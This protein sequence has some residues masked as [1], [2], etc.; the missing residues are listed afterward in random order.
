MV[1]KWCSHTMNEM[2][3]IAMVASTME[4]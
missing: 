4:R 3:Q 2:M 1:K